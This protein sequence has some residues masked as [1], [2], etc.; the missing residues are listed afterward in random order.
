MLLSLGIRWS[1]L[2]VC[3]NTSY[4]AGTFSF[5]PSRHDVVLS[6]YVFIDVGVRPYFILGWYIRCCVRHVVT[7]YCYFLGVFQ[8]YFVW[9]DASCPILVIFI[10]RI[11]GCSS[12]AYQLLGFS[13]VLILF[14]VVF[15]VY[16]VCVLYISLDAADI[17]ANLCGDAGAPIM[18]LG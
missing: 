16:N 15:V 18:F 17:G 12:I 7:F 3:V 1:R 6:P 5:C 14:S 10:A 4:W 2:F 11:F 13:V 8:G 9:Y